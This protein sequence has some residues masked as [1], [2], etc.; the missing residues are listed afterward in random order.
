MKV[1]REIADRLHSLQK[2]PCS[3]LKAF[4]RAFPLGDIGQAVYAYALNLQPFSRK[5]VALGQSG[6]DL[7]DDHTQTGVAYLIKNHCFIRIFLSPI[8]PVSL[9]DIAPAPPALA[10]IKRLSGARINQSINIKVFS[11]HGFLQV[12]RG[13]IQNIK[14]FLTIFRYIWRRFA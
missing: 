6:R 4:W 5:S 7:L 13:R 11:G 10:N 3:R 14:A 12:D 2:L 8:E 9:V 1:F